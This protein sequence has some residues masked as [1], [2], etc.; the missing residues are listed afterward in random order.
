MKNFP[1]HLPLSRVWGE[2]VVNA[3]GRSCSRV[4]GGEILYP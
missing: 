2:A 3:L 4:A 1:T